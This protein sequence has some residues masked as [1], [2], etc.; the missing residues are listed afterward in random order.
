MTTVIINH[1]MAYTYSWPWDNNQTVEGYSTA[2]PT[3]FIDDVAQ[4][5]GRTINEILDE[6]I[7]MGYTVHYGSQ[8]HYVLYKGDTK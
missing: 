8:Y 2:F 1:S 3:W 5:K 4:P 7:E 6:Y